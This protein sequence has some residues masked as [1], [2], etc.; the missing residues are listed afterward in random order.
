MREWKHDYVLS[1]MLWCGKHNCP[2]AGNNNQY[3][4]FYMCDSL[5]RGGRK[6]SDC[7]NL[8]KEELEELVLD[9]IKHKVYTRERIQE[10]V[11][12]LTESSDKNKNARIRGQIRKLEEEIRNFHKAIGEGFPAGSLI[13]PIAERERQK[14]SLLDQLKVHDIH[15]SADDIHTQV[16]E[17][18]DS[19]SPEIKREFVRSCVERIHISGNEVTINFSVANHRRVMVGR[20]ALRYISTNPISVLLPLTIFARTQRARK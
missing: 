7:P 18:I 8:A 13:E 3:K 10:A 4:K 16:L 11:D 20:T 15:V 5:R 9:T 14:Y 2:I 1:G 12:Y 19:G 17:I 6:A